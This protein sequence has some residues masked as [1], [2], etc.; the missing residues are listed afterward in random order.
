[1]GQDLLQQLRDIHYPPPI[2]IW[3]LTVGW[4]ILTFLILV[5]SSLIFY[6]WYKAYQKHRVKRLVLQRIEELEAQR[7][8]QLQSVS[9]ELSMLLKRAALAK[10]S[11]REVAGLHG[12]QW[13]AFLD[14]TAQTKDFSQGSGR[15]LIS[16]PYQLN[17]QMLPETIFH[18]IRDWVKKNL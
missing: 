1:M 3:P 4:Y 2:A 14:A 12:E 9:E 18:L 17:K 7:A 10:Y 16:T 6:V 13:L 11:R 5:A 15:L 8:D